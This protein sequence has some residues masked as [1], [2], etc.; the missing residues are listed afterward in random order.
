ML[1]RKQKAVAKLNGFEHIRSKFLKYGLVVA[2]TAK[3]AYIVGG[4]KKLRK[5]V[6]ELDLKIK[7]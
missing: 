5:F 7:V 6:K 3:N 1:H 4:R 2:E